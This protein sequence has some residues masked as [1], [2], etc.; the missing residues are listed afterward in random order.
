MKVSVRLNSKP[1]VLCVLPCVPVPADTGGTQRTLASVK[2]L[3][4][5]F[6]VTILAL[7]QPGSDPV[8]FRR[9]VSGRV[10]V[11][12]PGGSALWRLLSGPR[13]L[14]SGRPLRYA[15]YASPP[16]IAALERILRQHRFDLVHFDHPHMGQLLPT[17]RRLQPSAWAVLDEHNVEARVIEGFASLLHWPQRELLFRQAAR[18]RRLE[19]WLVQEADAT[20][21]CSD[22]DAKALR[23]MGARRVKVIPNGIRSDPAARS[24]AGHR[25][26]L[27]FIGSL[28]WPPNVDA[29]QR[30]AVRI[31][32]LARA[33]LPEARLVIAGRSPPP[34]I[35]SLASE[36]VVVTGRVESVAPVLRRARATAIPLRAGSG[37]RI[38][39]L[40]AW[41]ASVPVVANRLAAEGLDYVNQENV[42]IAETDQEFADSIAR[43]WED[44]VLATRLARGGERTAVRYE[45]SRIGDRLVET[46]FEWL[47]GS[48]GDEAQ[49]S[50]TP[51]YSSAGYKSANART[52]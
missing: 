4:R 35:R 2:A 52:S 20:L 9:Q 5:A 10:T 24:S 42:L 33:R 39:I 6:A 17:V 43:I 41:G 46:Y 45:Q 3:D 29:A 31:W 38:K 19:R 27:I 7:A 25:H 26:D 34:R 13:A 28:D 48:L 30:L 8:A 18:V 47:S 51:D 44:P 40:E 14:A 12:D 32:P 37:T 23:A 22:Q 1:S 36:R 49:G 11:V 50:A 15:R 21:A 16:V